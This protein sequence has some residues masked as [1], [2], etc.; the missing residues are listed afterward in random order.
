[1]QPTDAMQVRSLCVRSHQLHFVTLNQIGRLVET[2][3]PCIQHTF[4][5]MQLNVL[6]CVCLIGFVLVGSNLHSDAVLSSPSS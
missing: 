2:V 6:P 5:L 4:G 3:C 1:M